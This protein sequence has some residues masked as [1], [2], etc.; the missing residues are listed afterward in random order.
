MDQAHLI[1]QQYSRI[2]NLRK[3]NEVLRKEIELLGENNLSGENL[4]LKEEIENKDK[5]IKDQEQKLNDY[6]RV[7][8]KDQIVIYHLTHNLNN[9]EN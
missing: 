2:K 6:E 4:R 5:V 3:E 9:T 8:E 7:I 1:E